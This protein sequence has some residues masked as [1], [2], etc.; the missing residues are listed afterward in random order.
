L[1]LTLL[2]FH[3]DVCL[4]TFGVNVINLFDPA[5]KVMGSS[6]VERTISPQAEE[7]A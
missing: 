6:P 2:C 5:A 7:S 4:K 1:K 3:Y